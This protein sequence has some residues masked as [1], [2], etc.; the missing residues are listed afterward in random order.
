MRFLRNVDLKVAFIVYLP[1]RVGS[2]RRQ[3]MILID[4][5][6]AKNGGTGKYRS[7]TA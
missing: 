1:R 2:G 3:G 7:H 5:N 4:E 6:V